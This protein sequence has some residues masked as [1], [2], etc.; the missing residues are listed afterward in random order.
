MYGSCPRCVRHQEW[1]S[2]KWHGDENESECIPQLPALGPRPDTS[3]YV[4]TGLGGSSLIRYPSP[5][6][7][8]PCFV[9]FSTARLNQCLQNDPFSCAREVHTHIPLLSSRPRPPCLSGCKLPRCPYYC[10]FARQTAQSSMELRVDA[11]TRTKTRT[12]HA[13]YWQ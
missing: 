4:F 10:P 9:G 6:L 13:V 11:H 1:H 2:M 7:L 3:R 12:S 5:P 8:V